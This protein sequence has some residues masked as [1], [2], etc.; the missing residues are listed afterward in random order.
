MVVLVDVL[1]TGALLDKKNAKF[2]DRLMWDLV[3][4]SIRD[5]RSKADE[6]D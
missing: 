6:S 4:E 5:A 1:S 2:R 3:R